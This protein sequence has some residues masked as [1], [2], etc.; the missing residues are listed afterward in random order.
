[1]KVFTKVI[2]PLILIAAIVVLVFLLVPRGA[3]GP[4]DLEVSD[5]GTAELVDFYQALS[6]EDWNRAAGYVQTN[7]S[8]LETSYCMFDQMSFDDIKGELKEMCKTHICQPVE[9]DEID[10]NTKDDA[11]ALVHDIA[12]LNEDGTRMAYCLEER[13]GIKKLTTGM[14]VTNVDD[15]WY[16][17]DPMPLYVEKAE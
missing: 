7:C 1:M 17:V 16:V 6:E 3:D 5:K 14:R 2:L 12:F 11:G 8:Q 15:V 9:L 10:E 13:C 4:S